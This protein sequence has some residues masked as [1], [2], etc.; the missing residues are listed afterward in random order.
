MAA[1]QQSQFGQDG[2]QFEGKEVP[3]RQNVVLNVVEYGSK[4]QITKAGKKEYGII[5]GALDG[6]NGYSPYRNECTIHVM[7]PSIRYDPA[8]IGHEVT[9]CVWGE[10]HPKRTEAM[11]VKR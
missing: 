10:F 6:F 8:T 3:T 2:Y 5:A 7:D 11:T 1:C 9:H 4:L